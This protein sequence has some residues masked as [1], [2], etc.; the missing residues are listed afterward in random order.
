MS[1]SKPLGGRVALVGTGSRAAMFV[2]GIVA[3]PQ[4]QVVAICEPNPVRANYYNELLVQ[5]GAPKV[6]IYSPDGSKEM[7]SKEKV[8]TLVVTCV[9]ALHDV[10]IVPALEAGVRVLTEK[11]MTTDVD[12]CR[13]ILEAV[14]RTGQHVTVTFNY[15]Q[16]VSFDHLSGNPNASSGKVLSVHFEWLLDTVHGADYFRRW[17]RQKTNSGGLMVHKSGHHF[18]LVNWWIDARPIAVAGMGKLAFYGDKAGKEHGWAKDYVRAR[19]AQAAKD[20]PFA[21]MLEDDETLKKIYA[22]AEGED[23]YHRDQNVFAPGI[24]IEDDM[25]VLVQYNTGA[26]L[27]YHLTAYSPWEGYRVMFNGSH[28]RLELEVVESTHRTASDPLTTGGQIHGTAA[29]PNPGPVTVKVQRLWEPAQELPVQ[30]EHGDH[31]GGDKRMLNVLFGPLP[32]ESF[33]TGDA[34]KQSADERDGTYALAVG[35]MANESF[36]TGKFVTFESLGLGI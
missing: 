13:R 36:K 15:R 31:G 22:N 30:Y 32:G 11:P 35:L 33:D 9:D 17:H 10:Y 6:P 34:S 20:D 28:G 26:T 4:C 24:G 25:A 21:I 5:L 18:D 23:G 16:V 3:R 1:N 12:K 2:R 8:E 29:L 19:G 27:S 7:L 14:E